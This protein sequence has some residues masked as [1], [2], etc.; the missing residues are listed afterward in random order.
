MLFDIPSMKKLTQVPYETEY[1]RLRNELDQV[2][3]GAFAIIH[4]ELIS[5]FDGREIDTA[6]WIPGKHWQD[7]PWYPIYLAAGEDEEVPGKF[8]GQIVWQVV[9]DHHDC[10]SSG[11]YELDGIPIKSRTYF[12][13]DCP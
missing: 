4:Q 1:R 9:M 12:R 6:G 7:T 13:I 10:W 2:S 3:P 5:R 8:F 11:R